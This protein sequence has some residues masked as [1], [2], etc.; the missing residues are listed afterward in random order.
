MNFKVKIKNLNV[1]Y[2]CTNYVT[3][4]KSFKIILTGDF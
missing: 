4:T 3:E 2:K 1:N